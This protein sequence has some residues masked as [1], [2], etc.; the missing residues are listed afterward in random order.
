MVC[1][2]F[3]RDQNVIHQSSFDLDWNMCFK[4]NW[5]YACKNLA[6]NIF[7]EMALYDFGLDCHEFYYY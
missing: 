3:F 4:L 6:Q 7:Y 1:I 2:L 5:Q